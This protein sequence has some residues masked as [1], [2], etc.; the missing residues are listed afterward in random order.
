MLTV[1]FSLMTLLALI[2]ETSVAQ[3]DPRPSRSDQNDIVTTAASSGNFDTLV[4]L[5]ITSGLD[6][7]IREADNITVFAPTDDAFAKLPN[8]VLVSLR[9]AENRDK[10][11]KILKLH[12]ATTE[13]SI[14]KRPPSHP[15]KSAKTLLGQKLNFE[16]KGNDVFVN[17]AKVVARNI[18]CTNGLVHAIDS[19]LL[20]SETEN[21]LIGVAE[22]AGNFKTLLTAVKSAGLADALMG[23]GPFTVLAPTD[24]AFSAI[25]KKDLNE[26]LKPENQDKLAAIL[27]LHVISGLLP[28]KD[29]VA[30]G[31]AKSIAGQQIRF[32]V[33]SGRIS[34]ADARILENDIQ[35]D[36]GIIHVIDRVLLPAAKSEH[37]STS[38][39]KSK[40]LKTKQQ[41]SH[42]ERENRKT[43]TPWS[44]TGS[45]KAN[46]PAE[47]AGNDSS[48]KSI[49]ITAGWNDNV[50]RDGI[51]A[52]LITIRCTG[53]G[54]VKLTNVQAQK[55][56]TSVLGGSSA[57]ISGTVHEHDA[58][59]FGGATLRSSK[60]IAQNTNIHVNGGGQATVNSVQS[61][62][63]KA[64]GGADLR[65][66]KTDAKIS[67]T[68]NKYAT[69][70][71]IEHGQ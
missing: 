6:E 22:K 56:V 43:Q 9:K 71:P 44:T 30:A 35:A 29:A 8:D 15:T 26:L 70:R 57:T 51:K 37:T 5:L 40:T 7:A 63:A 69:F 67:K 1:A 52:D 65:Y 13:I 50:V 49:T 59:V 17:N 66:V 46:A 18:R 54:S 38:K 45:P 42:S 34:V 2:A 41:K 19:V 58:K 23:K 28:V 62:T 11:A 39:S 21:T 48:L 32:T 31:D 61:L 68:I 12:V 55:I 64:N 10:L 3:K 53:G 20:P 33:K 36:N 24:K 14:A 16:R 25:P 60:L 27:K 47:K 4:S